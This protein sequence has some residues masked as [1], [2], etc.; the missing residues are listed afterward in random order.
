MTKWYG[1]ATEEEYLES[2]LGRKPIF[3]DVDTVADMT[4][5]DTI[6]LDLCSFAGVHMEPGTEFVMWVPVRIVT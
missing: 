2:N 4:N 5:F 3:V 6:E 1:L